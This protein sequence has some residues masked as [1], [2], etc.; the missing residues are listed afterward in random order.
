MYWLEKLCEVGSVVRM[1][2]V[3]VTLVRSRLASHSGES[4][5]ALTVQPVLHGSNDRTAL[6]SRSVQ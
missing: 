4:S 2:S 6:C 5:I 3:P 1:V